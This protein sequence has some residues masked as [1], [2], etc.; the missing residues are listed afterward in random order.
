MG[1]LLVLLALSTLLDPPP[2]DINSASAEDLAELVGIGTA[3]AS[4]IVEFRETI[5]PFLTVDEL[6]FVPGVG[7]SLLESIQ[8]FIV[9]DSEECSFSRADTLPIRCPEDTLL[10]VVF[11]DIGNGDAILL[12]TSDETWLIDGGPP[13]DGY[14]RAPVVQR[15]IETGID[16][17]STVA[18]THPHADHIGGC[19]DAL[20]V[21]RCTNLI[22]PGISH[23]SPLYEDLLEYALTS[24][25]TYSVPDLG[26]S[27]DLGNG[28]KV[29]VVMLERGACSPNEASAVYLVTCGSFSLLVTGDIENESI[30]QMTR[31]QSP[32]TVMKVPHHGSRSSLFPPWIRRCDPQVAVFCCGRQNPFGHPDED[33]VEAWRQTG[34]AILRT[35]LSGN[36]FLYTDGEAVT[37]TLS[38]Q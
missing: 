7:P 25:C 11:L 16:T 27:W 38:I 6:L 26:D 14:L 12:E 33:V 5:S 2:M 35:D 17:L 19:R 18:F 34:A 24:D 22:D 1:T 23:S 9:A 13:G 4:S 10:S 31:N 30:M 28:V 29:E 37:F 32:V 15:L 21:F 36:I 3:T 20:E 8:S